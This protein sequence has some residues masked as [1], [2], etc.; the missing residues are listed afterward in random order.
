VVYFIA[1]R[2]VVFYLSGEFSPVVEVQ[3]R[4]GKGRGGKGKFYQTFLWST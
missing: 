4:E 2:E 1:C 3:G